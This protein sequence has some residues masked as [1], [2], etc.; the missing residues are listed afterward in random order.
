M[1][2]AECG[3]VHEGRS[4]V[5][6]VKAVLFFETLRLQPSLLLPDD[7]HQQIQHIL[8]PSSEVFAPAHRPG[9][10]QFKFANVG[11]QPI[12][13]MNARPVHAAGTK[14]LYCTA[15]SIAALMR[16]CGDLCYI[17]YML[18]WRC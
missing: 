3:L 8:F 17:I 7:V 14:P 4:Q 9:R 10:S 1:G 11:H 18:R 2:P 13:H 16:I 12:K 15:S 5:E 6:A